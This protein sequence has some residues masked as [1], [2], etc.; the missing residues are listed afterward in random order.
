VFFAMYGAEVHGFDLSPKGIEMARQIAA[1]NGVAG[2]CHFRV[3]N[4]SRMPYADAS[5]DVVV[6]NA[7]LHH[8]VKYP[9]V[10]DEIRRVLKHGGRLYF[11]EGVRDNGLYRLVRRLRR[12]LRP[13]HYHGDVDLEI[14][15]LEQLTQ[16]YADVRIEQFA[17][18]E[19]FAEGFGRDYANGWGV[20]CVY[21]A[22]HL[23][24]K[25]MLALVPPLRR[26]CLEVV[27][28]AT[29]P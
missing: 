14:S 24:D 7:V 28:V 25:A 16:G 18:L 6:C 1:A 29:K 13:V 27:G 10:R 15:D 26:H 21:L 22:T 11:A 5:F 20:R 8:I 3:A 12:K 2:R 4:V 23:V 9:N 17:L 19:K